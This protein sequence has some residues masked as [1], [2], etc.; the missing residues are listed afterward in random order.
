M[1]LTRAQ[2]EVIAIAFLVILCI[3]LFVGV[4]LLIAKDAHHTQPQLDVT[5]ALVIFDRGRQRAQLQIDLLQ[6]LVAPLLWSD[7]IIVLRHSN[8]VPVGPQ[9]DDVDTD[10]PVF[11]IAVPPSTTLEQA[12]INCVALSNGTI[13]EDGAILFLG[14]YTVPIKPV[15]KEFLFS[16]SRKKYAL[17]NYISP[18][19]LALQLENTI[20]DTMPTTITITNMLY[21]Y[22]T[23]INYMITVSTG[24]DYVFAVSINQLIILIGNSMVDDDNLQTTATDT[25]VFN[26]VLLKKQQMTSTTLNTK[27]IKYWQTIL[28][29]IE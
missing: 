4:V 6:K 23:A 25:E 14:D 20:E 28:D 8:L 5:V 11:D 21:A 3:A 12:F 1:N 22:N 18:D 29:S 24:N 17:F 19:E 16:L 7:R 15:T 10:L 27:I 13:D 9:H 26:T 2:K